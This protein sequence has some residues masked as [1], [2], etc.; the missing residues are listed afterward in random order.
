VPNQNRFRR[1]RMCHRRTNS[2]CRLRGFQIA[3]LVKTRDGDTWINAS[4]LLKRT[5]QKNVSCSL[6]RRYSPRYT[7][8][9]TKRVADRPRLIEFLGD[10]GERVPEYLLQL[11]KFPPGVAL[12]QNTRCV[13]NGYG[14]SLAGSN[15]GAEDVTA[16]SLRIALERSTPAT[17]FLSRRAFR[18]VCVA[19]DLSTRIQPCA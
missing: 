11:I 1:G 7:S 9:S 18:L 12:A 5:P 16:P 17:T 19:L 4:M 14:S 6:P 3:F 10:F 15:G 13:H 2:A 8:S